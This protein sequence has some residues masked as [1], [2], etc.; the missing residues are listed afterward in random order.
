MS[1]RTALGVSAIAIA[2]LAFG[3]VVVRPSAA[4]ANAPWGGYQNGQ[5]PLSALVVVSY[6]GIVPF[7]YPGSLAPQLY[8]APGVDQKLLQLLQAYH[9]ATGSYLRV[10]D[11]YRTLAGQNYW[12]SQGQQG[13][14]GQSNHGWGEAV[15]FDKGLLT[16]AQALWL[17]N[18]GGA[19]G[20]YPLENDYGHY[21]YTGNITPGAGGEQ[22]ARMA[23]D[24]AV[25]LIW[26]QHLSTGGV[27][28]YYRGYTGTGHVEDSLYSQDQ[29]NKAA[30]VIGAATLTV[31]SA[32]E[33]A[34]LQTVLASLPA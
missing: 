6:P 25:R 4:A 2:G 19:Y 11:G 3:D 20:F 5:I 30:Q 7:P 15:D 21:N 14:P 32:A 26:M 24:M 29:A 23:P 1:R 31:N 18:N 34:S 16:P 10:S 9:S 12:Y 33:L 17:T 22:Q 28:V 13:P 8:L 27:N